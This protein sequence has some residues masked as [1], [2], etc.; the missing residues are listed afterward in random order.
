MPVAGAP[1][2][3]GCSWLGGN[4]QAGSF[5]EN[6]VLVQKHSCFIIVSSTLKSGQSTQNPVKSNTISIAQ[7]QECSNTLKSVRKAQTELTN[8]CKPT[9]QDGGRS[10]SG[11]TKLKTR[12]ARW[13]EKGG[14]KYA[15]SFPHLGTKTP[16]TENTIQRTSVL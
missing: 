15:L 8:C 5:T 14:G 11:A 10:R 9:R 2:N 6:K 3:R 12:G 16:K 13:S 7:H 1:R 4:T